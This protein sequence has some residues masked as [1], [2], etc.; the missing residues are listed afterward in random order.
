MLRRIEH[1]GHGR[2]LTF[3][4]Y[5]R[6]PLLSNDRIKDALVQ[7]LSHVKTQMNFRLYAWVVMPEHVHLLLQTAS[8]ALTVE[9]ILNTLKARFAQQ[10]IRRWREPNASILRQITDARGVCRFWQTGG[11]YDRNIVSDHEFLENIHYIHDNPVR[12]ELVQKP[13]EW[14]WSS[15]RWYEG[16]RSFGPAMD[17]P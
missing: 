3:S 17:S 14:K 11:G 12:R 6:L 8:P 16:D 2:Y 4:C 15:A 13:V 1:P 7:R 5:R 9:E 10:I